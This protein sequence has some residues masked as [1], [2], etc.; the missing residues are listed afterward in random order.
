MVL[1]SW[2][3]S[4]L[5]AALAF[6]SAMQPVEVDV[7]PAF[8]IG[9]ETVSRYLVEKFRQR[10]ADEFIQTQNRNPSE[11]EIESWQRLFVAKAVVTAHAR[12]KG[13]YERAEVRDIV[14]R[15]ERYMLT[16]PAGPFYDELYRE[17]R[18]GAEIPLETLYHRSFTTLDVQVVVFR[19]DCDA[20]KLLG[21]DFD[22]L[23]TDEQTRRALQ[24]READEADFHD[25]LFSWPYFG[26][27]EI[28][29]DVESA[30]VGRWVKFERPPFGAY[31]VH[32]RSVHAGKPGDFAAARE[33]FAAL[34]E[35]ERR[36]T[37]Q[38]RRRCD[39]LARASFS[40]DL[41]A[42]RALGEK[43]ALLP[44]EATQIP[45]PGESDGE[46][47]LFRY[48]ADSTLIEVT[49]KAFAHHFNQR[50]VRRLPRDFGQVRSAAEDMALEELDFRAARQR[51]IHESLKFV[52]DR[53]GFMATRALEL[54]EREVL[55][56]Q[57]SV[58]PAEIERYYRAH[59]IDYRRTTKVR[60]RL[61][62]F[63]TVEE[64]LA[65]LNQS[66]RQSSA[67]AFPD[68]HPLTTAD[69]EMDA[70]HPW[71]GFEAWQE[72]IFQGPVGT[73][74]IGPVLSG[75]RMVVFTKTSNLAT[76]LIP[77][78][79]LTDTIRAALLRSALDARIVELAQELAPQ[80][81]VET[82][83]DYQKYCV[84]EPKK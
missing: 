78:P 60:G 11:A 79:E 7:R 73:T 19:K 33:N 13:Y 30:A 38:L 22:Q 42:V 74:P 10:H 28:A 62:S 76:E 21:E 12:E 46:A 47:V 67:E 63:A 20:R 32:V 34:V 4:T 15:M 57:V 36:K 55:A 8:K 61:V 54:F 68:P 39:L 23:S 3:G 31:Y 66:T 41:V 9:G 80:I 75:D 70:G 16:Q 58:G 50:L 43:C 40:A 1:C 56:P 82:E 52:E 14:A 69:V 26:F 72:M 77:L 37:I 49:V 81:R 71:P 5:L 64:A 48:E 6:G 29:D 25:G 24:C 83:A 84:A 17:C 59:E 65:W 51:H 44:P 27:S 18:G 35:N 2:L 53:R 45:A